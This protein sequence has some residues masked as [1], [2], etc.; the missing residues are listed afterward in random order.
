MMVEDI[1]FSYNYTVIP[2]ECV[3]LLGPLSA[4][5]ANGSSSDSRSYRPI[6]TIGL[7]THRD[8]RISLHTKRHACSVHAKILCPMAIERPHKA[9]SLIG[10]YNI[11]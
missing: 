9:A 3:I 11:A 5:G 8:G 2:T 10:Y 1:N 6:I 4:D 7:G